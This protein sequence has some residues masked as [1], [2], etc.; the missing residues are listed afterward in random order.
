MKYSTL[1]VLIALSTYFSSNAQKYPDL[2]VTKSGDSLQCRITVIDSNAT[3]IRVKINN[4]DRIT[5][6]KNDQIRVFEWVSEFWGEEFINPK[7][8]ISIAPTAGFYY[9]RSN[10]PVLRFDGLREASG[11]FLANIEIQYLTHVFNKTHVGAGLSFYDFANKMH[12]PRIYLQVEIRNDGSRKVLGTQ[13]QAGL[14]LGKIESKYF[15]YA[16]FGLIF[17]NDQLV[18][19]LSYHIIPSV[20]LYGGEKVSRVECDYR[21]P[22]EICN[23]YELK[24]TTIEFNISVVFQLALSPQAR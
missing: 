3:H 10:N 2:V 6:V 9:S 8:L 12:I 1:I 4:L 15:P 22:W 17:R 19:K 20:K 14:T 7:H 13:V 21:M 23:D 18:K 24:F 11:G 16:G 5:Y